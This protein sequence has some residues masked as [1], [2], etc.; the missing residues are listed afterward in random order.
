MQMVVTLQL[1]AN[2]LTQR[3]RAGSGASQMYAGVG[4]SGSPAPKPMT[5]TP[6]A[7]ISFA[8]ASIASVGEGA[9]F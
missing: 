5:S 6:A 8:R 2:R 9:I 3:D 7:F 1:V 4:K